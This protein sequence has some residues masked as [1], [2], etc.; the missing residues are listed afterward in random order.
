MPIDLLSP[1]DPCHEFNEHIEYVQNSRVR[2]DRL[3]RH[4]W[5]LLRSVMRSGPLA[6]SS[7]VARHLY[8]TRDERS[9]DAIPA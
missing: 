6:S 4:P 9:S 8:H 5:A 1:V 7:T 2:C 3:Q